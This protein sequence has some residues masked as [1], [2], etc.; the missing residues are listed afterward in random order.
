M[1]KSVF[2]THFLQLPDI[3]IFEIFSYLSNEDALFAF[4]GF[5]NIR[6]MNLLTE[7]GAFRQ[8]YLSPQLCRRQY[9]KLSNGIWRYD[10]VRSLVCKEMFSDAFLYLLPCQRFPSLVEL[11]LLS[12][13]GFSE[14]C[15]EFVIAHSS[16]L[17]HLCIER[18]E[19]PF[20]PGSYEEFLQRVLPHL[21]QLKF[22]NADWKS[23]FPVY[24]VSNTILIRS[25]KFCLIIGSMESIEWLFTIIRIFVYICR[26]C[27]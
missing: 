19:Q 6:M 23:C 5:N 15:L 14:S 3:V 27:L 18:S 10:L 21:T 13:C 4:T 8:I 17:T 25:N 22:L 24:Y 16:T 12:V 26:W 7:Y 2:K 1:N 20:L 11:K 9:Y